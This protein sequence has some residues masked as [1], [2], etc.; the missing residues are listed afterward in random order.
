MTTTLTYQDLER[1]VGERWT[2]DSDDQF[3]QSD[4]SALIANADA[5]VTLDTGTSTESTTRDVL[6]ITYA[7]YLY[8]KRREVASGVTPSQLSTRGSNS[9]EILDEYRRLLAVF[10]ST[11]YAQYHFPSVTT[12]DDSEVVL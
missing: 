2:D 8:A 11:G 10:K 9:K 6:V 5:V 3:T 7:A 4:A 12:G 1:L